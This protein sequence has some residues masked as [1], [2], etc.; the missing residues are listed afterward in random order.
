MSSAV[1]AYSAMRSKKSR[2]SWRKPRVPRASCKSAGQCTAAPMPSRCPARISPI[3]TSCSGPESSF[4]ANSTPGR[5]PD[6]C[7]RR[8]RSKAYAAHARVGAVDMLRLIRRAS[9][10]R[11]RV[12]PARVGVST[13]SRAGS[14]PAFRK[15]TAAVITR[16]VLPVPGAPRMSVAVMALSLSGFLGATQM[17]PLPENV[18]KHRAFTRKLR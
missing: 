10:S 8:S 17:C 16:S 12:A 4:G 14:P 3:I 5:S 6:T 9:S 15:S 1:S 2:I 11:T 13:K 18:T 7:A